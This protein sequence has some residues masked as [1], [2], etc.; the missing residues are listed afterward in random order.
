MHEEKK[1]K[2]MKAGG[3]KKKVIKIKSKHPSL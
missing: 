2:V 3:S 1:M